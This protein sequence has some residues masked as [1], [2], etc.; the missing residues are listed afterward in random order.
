M[1][2]VVTQ[3]QLSHVPDPILRGDVAL[4]TFARSMKERHLWLSRE[5]GTVNVLAKAL[6]VWQKLRPSAHFDLAHAASGSLPT[7]HGMEEMTSP[8]FRRS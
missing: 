7:S 6:Y 5:T 2:Q 1:V 4:A 3:V 8:L